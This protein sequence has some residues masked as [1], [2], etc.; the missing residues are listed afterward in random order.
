MTIEQAIQ[1]HLLNFLEKRKASGD[2]RP[3]GPHD[4]APLYRA[5]FGSSKDDLKDEKFLS[6][7]RRAGST[8]NEDRV[9][10]E[11]GGK[12]KQKGGKKR[13]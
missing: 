7:L 5:V 1:S 4:L 10:G 6:R 9:P 8:R 2:A 3:C 11:S 12:Q 13:Q